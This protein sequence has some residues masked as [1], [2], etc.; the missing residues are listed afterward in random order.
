MDGIASR[1]RL[2]IAQLAPER[3]FR[4]LMSRQAGWGPA[5]VLSYDLDF[6][7]DIEVL[8]RLLQL[9]EARS[10]QGSFAC[11][12]RWVR[13]F[14]DLHRSIVAAGHEILNHTENHPNLYHE[15][16]DYARAEGL[17]RER[18]DRIGSAARRREI[19]AGHATLGDVLGVEAEG[20]RTPH[21]GSLHT[22]DVHEILQDMGYRFSSS[23]MCWRTATGLPYEACPGLW[24]FPL[25][26]CP[27]HP[28]GVFDSWHALGKNAGSH[29]E[30]GAL[31][32]LLRQ[33]LETVSEQGGFANIYL[34]PR[35]PLD[36]GELERILDVAQSGAVPFT[37]YGAL[38]RQLLEPSDEAVDEVLRLQQ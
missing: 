10:I 17:C 28:L 23:T 4:A 6:P 1:L 8:P 5:G 9:M 37:T 21:F 25:S 34:D 2:A 26:P 24:E 16:Y 30:P 3:R 35:D 20:F 7:R 31:A 36:S 15:H 13:E 27:R 38:C 22:P 29:G 18:F 32:A 12:G 33:L 11:I 19:E 14:P